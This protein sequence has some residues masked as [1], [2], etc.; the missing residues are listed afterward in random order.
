M[1]QREASD[2]SDL[3]LS[4]EK[5][6]LLNQMEMSDDRWSGVLG[7]LM[8]TEVTATFGGL[9]GDVRWDSL[10]AGGVVVVQNMQSLNF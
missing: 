9:H 3:Q 5:T 10:E 7:S 4:F 8:E 2:L 1:R 6:I